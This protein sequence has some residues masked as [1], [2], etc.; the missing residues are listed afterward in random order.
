MISMGILLACCRWAAA[1]NP[2]VDMNQY[3]HT[4]WTIREGFFKGTVTSIAQTPDGYI[5]LGTEF[6]LLHFDGVRGVPWQS[7]DRE[8]LLGGVVRVLLVT[9]DGRLWIGTDKGLASWR[10]GKLTEYPEFAGQS[11]R[12]LVEDREAMVWA[13]VYRIPT[14]KLC[15]IKSG[16]AQCYGEDGSLG[17]YVQSLYEDRAGNLWAGAESG[18]WRW[19]PGPTKLYTMPDPL[20]SIRS[21]LEDENGALLIAM[22]GGVRKLVGLKTDAYPLPGAGRQVKASIPSRLLWDRDGGLWIGTTDQG[23]LHL[24]AGRTDRFALSD[25]LSANYV[26]SLF[27]DREGNI[28]VATLDGLDRFRDYPIPT[29][30]VKQGLSNAVVGSVLAARDGSVW[31][32]TLDGLNRLKNGRMTIYRKRIGLLPTHDREG[33][34]QEIAD[35]GLPD[36][37][38]ESLYEDDRGRIWVSTPQGIAYFENGRFVPLSTVPHGFVHSIA[39]DNAGNLWISDDQSLLRWQSGGTVERTPWAKLGRKDPAFTL[40]RDPVQGGLWL[41]FH[42]SGVAYLKDGQIRESHTADDGLSEGSVNGFQLDRDGTLWVASEGGLGRLKNGRAALLT[43][44]NG[45]PCEAVDWVTEDDA[46][47]FW[48]NMPCGLVRIAHAELDAWAIDTK[49]PIQTTVFDSSDGV[50]SH[51][52]TSTY[53]PRVAKS[54]DGKL[55]FLPYDGVSVVDPRHLPTNKLPPPVHVE[56]VN[57]DGKTYDASTGL[58]LP[59]LLRDLWIDYTALS[60]VAPDK[61]R[62]RYKLE[63]RDRDWRDAG[64]RRRAFYNDLPPGNYRF[65]VSASNDSGV[66]NEAGAFLDFRVP[67]AYYQATWFRLSCVAAFL[68]LPGA[69]YQLRLRQLARQFNVRLEE[70]GRERTRIAQD[71]HDTLLQNIAGLC[72][73][74]GGLAK[75]VIAHPESAQARLQGLREQG[76]E[77]QREARRVVWNLRSLESESVDLAT[78]MRGSGERLTSQTPVRFIFRVEGEPRRVALELREQILRIGTEAIANSVRH[79][80]A[81][82]IEARISFEGNRIRLRISDDGRGFAVDGAAAPGHFGLTTMRERAQQIGASIVISSEPECGTSIEVTVPL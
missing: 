76:E 77:C 82:T 60:F 20:P 38:V 19:K 34:A 2:S 21:L 45:L 61:V 24:H 69:L 16:G 6:G 7:T 12:A 42:Q 50:I 43:S 58:R 51:S 4:A 44:K 39:T 79:A 70:R 52:R 10:N 25:G 41:G 48:L 11:I 3:A 30:S 27:E 65:R 22:R 56:R 57:A 68:A 14:G 81:E 53:S 40:F 73:Q 36:G 28:W 15:A 67:P 55:W 37:A 35:G 47:S 80:H 1:L 59:P 9:R 54:S 66:W 5:W 26:T 71:L 75:V 8:N 32:G 23:L 64:N 31:L 17:Q 13:G 62:F 29:I 18:L 63:G 72:L 46:Q 74:I 33:L 78:E 49:R